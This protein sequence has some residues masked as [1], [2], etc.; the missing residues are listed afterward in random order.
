FLLGPGARLLSLEKERGF[1]ILLP[2]NGSRIRLLTPHRREVSLALEDLLQDLEP[3]CNRDATRVADADEVLRKAGLSGSRRSRVLH[4]LESSATTL[5]ADTPNGCRTGWLLRLPPGAPFS[6]QLSE[7]RLPRLAVTFVFAFLAHYAASLFAWVVL[8]RMVLSQRLEGPGVGLWFLLMLTLV[9]LRLLADWSRGVFSFGVGA[10]LKRR[11]LEGAFRLD[12]E[13]TRT[14]GV[15]RALGRVLESEALEA[16]SLNSAFAALRAG[17]ELTVTF[18]VL[19][20]GAGGW[21][22]GALLLIF[23]AITAG[24]GRW[25]WL[26]QRRWVDRRLLL[27]DDLVENMAGHATRRVQQ[28]SAL[29]HCREDTLLAAYTSAA[30]ILDRTRVFLEVLPR[31]WLAA[32]IVVLAPDLA[33]RTQDPVALAVAV[34]GS[35][36]AYRALEGLSV[37]LPKLTAAGVAWMR[38]RPIFDAGRASEAGPACPQGATSS[39]GRISADVLQAR[40][41]QYFF[42]DRPEAVIEN[43]TLNLRRGSCHLIVGPSGGGKS[44]LVSLLAGHR[45][46]ARGTLLLDGLD[47]F[48]LG[49]QTWRRRVALVPQF[50]ENHLFSESFLFNLLLAR[51]WPPPPRD[52]AAALEVC[53]ALGLGPLLSKMPGGIFQMVGETGWQLSH[54]ERSRVFLARA[55]LQ[56]ADVVILDESLAALDRV[57]LEETLRSAVA[58]SPTL[59]VVAHP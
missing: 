13:Q 2:S 49:R 4:C 19:L 56:G 33:L 3:T 15:G 48:V 34:G 44:T 31:L 18:W 42:P 1:L 37:G 35:L 28:L 30:E 12:P 55:L 46:P 59:L 10:R 26:H 45:A 8:A 38:V 16:N 17:L 43:A 21:A 47:G 22:H 40:G 7:A 11:L 6:A 25:L 41:L 54:G 29:R 14:L 53:E 5:E 9:P 39:S 24:L 50:H 23:I 51:E 32:A 52:L 57:S 27:T 20:Q 36:L 58:R